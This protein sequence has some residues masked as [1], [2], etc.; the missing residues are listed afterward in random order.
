VTNNK[1]VKV[2][3][4]FSKPHLRVP[5]ATYSTLQLR[6]CMEKYP[7]NASCTFRNSGSGSG[8]DGDG[9]E[10]E[11]EEEIDDLIFIFI[12]ATRSFSCRIIS[13]VAHSL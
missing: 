6:Q 11:D 12:S 7:T 2:Q 9:D 4:S 10:Q 8:G 5:F 13:F 3:I 1:N